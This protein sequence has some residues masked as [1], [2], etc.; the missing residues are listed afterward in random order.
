VYSAGI[1]IIDCATIGFML[2]Y[3]WDV[4]KC[5]QISCTCNAEFEKQKNLLIIS[6]TGKGERER[7]REEKDKEKGYLINKIK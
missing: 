2:E 7:E 6:N 5:R 3:F 1:D 4:N